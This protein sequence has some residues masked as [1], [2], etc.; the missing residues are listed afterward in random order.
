MSEETPRSSALVPRKQ[1]KT[2]DNR[3]REQVVLK[4][5]RTHGAQFGTVEEFCDAFGP[6][7]DFNYT[8]FRKRKSTHRRFNELVTKIYEGFSAARVLKNV[9]MA[10][11]LAAKRWPHLEE[12]KGTFLERFRETNDRVLSAEMVG[13]TW[14][15]IELE[16]EKDEQFRAG[17]S[18]VWDELVIKAEDSA[19]RKAAAGLG[20]AASQAVL[21]TSSKVFSKAK[22]RASLNN[23]GGEVRASID[24]TKYDVE[25]TRRRAKE[26]FRRTSGPVTGAPS[27]AAAPPTLA[28]A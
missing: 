23:D 28:D 16:L 27:D 17:F 18:E 15:E 1:K 2:A 26:L 22:Q 6:A 14:V 12:W 21:E 19:L 5:Y 24:A 3:A 13:R 10:P 4:L 7:N 8:W 11:V 20:G 25:A 9:T